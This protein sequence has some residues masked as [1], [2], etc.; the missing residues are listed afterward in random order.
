MEE[1][2]PFFSLKSFTNELRLYEDHLEG[3]FFG[4]DLVEAFGNR[5]YRLRYPEVESVLIKETPDGQV[6]ILE[7]NYDGKPEFEKKHLLPSNLFFRKSRKDDIEKCQRV[8]TLIDY[9]RKN[10]FET[11]MVMKIL[12]PGKE[13]ETP[14]KRSLK[15]TVRLKRK[16]LLFF[17]MF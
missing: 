14:R 17:N 13:N 1:Q 9:L 7:I 10:P 6:K 2:K 16:I 11:E 5:F 8:K 4:K 12:Y 15:R 3:E